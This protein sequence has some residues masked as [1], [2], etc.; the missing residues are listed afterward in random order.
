MF[1]GITGFGVVFLLNLSLFL[2][3]R[4]ESSSKVQQERGGVFF[5]SRRCVEGAGG[6]VRQQSCG[7]GRTGETPNGW[8]WDLDRGEQRKPSQQLHFVQPLLDPAAVH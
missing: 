7:R 6:T 3:V 4:R 5:W 8:K 1:S 2:G